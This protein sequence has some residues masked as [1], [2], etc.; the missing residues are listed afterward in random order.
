VWA[1]WTAEAERDEVRAGE[2][3]L[4]SKGPLLIVHAA[5]SVDDGWREG[6][7]KGR[8]RKGC[9]VRHKQ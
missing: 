4:E 7:A 5:F 6:E 1:V 8:I 2:G 9:I 3:R